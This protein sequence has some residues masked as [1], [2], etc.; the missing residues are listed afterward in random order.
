MS[1]C[2]GN[3]RRVC[4]NEGF[5][6]INCVYCARTLFQQPQWSKQTSAKCKPFSTTFKPR[7]QGWLAVEFVPF[8]SHPVKLVLIAG[9]VGGSSLKH[10]TSIRSAI[11][12]IIGCFSCSETVAKRPNRRYMCRMYSGIVCARQIPLQLMR[13]NS[14][15]YD[16]LNVIVEGK[17]RHLYQYCVK[18]SRENFTYYPLENL[19]LYNVAIYIRRIGRYI[20]AIYHTHL[21]RKQYPHPPHIK[22]IKHLI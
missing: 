18:R 14:T 6:K 12:G 20:T 22:S 10:R 5:R 4:F 17:W 13:F 1:E 16:V 15:T 8:I 3:S 21:S 19:R 7:W 9:P 11:P 2:L